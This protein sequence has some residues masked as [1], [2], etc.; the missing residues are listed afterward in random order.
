M[1]LAWLCASLAKSRRMESQDSFEF[2]PLIVDH[3]ARHGSSIEAEQ[4][5]L[6]LRALGRTGTKFHTRP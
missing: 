3:K 1:A 5:S 6:R 2:I 4:T